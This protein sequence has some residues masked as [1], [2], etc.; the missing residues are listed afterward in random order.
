MGSDEMR[1]HAHPMLANVIGGVQF[2]D[3]SWDSKHG[4][5]ANRED[6]KENK[7]GIIVSTPFAASWCAG[8]GCW[9]GRIIGR[10]VRGGTTIAGCDGSRQSE[11]R[12]RWYAVRL[13]GGESRCVTCGSRDH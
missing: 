13:T 9:I 10:R 11:R 8:A 6:R 2:A 7:S 12:V 4:R 5:F 3:D 1:L